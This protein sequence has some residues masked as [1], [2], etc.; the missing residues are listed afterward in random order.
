MAL[1]VLGACGFMAC[2]EDEPSVIDELI[3]AGIIDSS[4]DVKALIESGVIDANDPD[5]LNQL[6]EAGIVD[7]NVLETGFDANI[8]FDANTGDDEDADDADDGPTSNSH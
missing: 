3:E 2:G 8:F 7:A 4:T 1:I 5:V 6:V